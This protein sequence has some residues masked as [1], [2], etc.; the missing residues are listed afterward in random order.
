MPQRSVRNKASACMKHMIAIQAPISAKA[1]LADEP[2]QLGVTTP[3]Y[4]MHFM[5]EQIGVRR[6]CTAGRFR[7]RTI[8]PTTICQISTVCDS[9]GM[10]TPG[11]LEAPTRPS[12][13]IALN[14]SSL[15]ISHRWP[16]LCRVPV[17]ETIKS[18]SR[19]QGGTE[20]RETYLG[21]SFCCTN[22]EE[23][24]LVGNL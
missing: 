18:F 8:L 14:Y 1:H 4:R 20:Q 5:R 17:G 2:P 16:T 22:I 24:L 13:W 11:I 15:F 7:P 3:M 10:T 6:T 23:D 19:D 12:T 9:N 21:Q